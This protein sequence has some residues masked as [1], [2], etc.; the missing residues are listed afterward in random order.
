MD[1]KNI[2]NRATS[3][4]INGVFIELGGFVPIG[5]MEGWSNGMMGLKA[6]FCNLNSLFKLL[7]PVFHSSLPMT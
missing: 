6:C 7:H 3:Q 4:E 5:I 2:K 1:L